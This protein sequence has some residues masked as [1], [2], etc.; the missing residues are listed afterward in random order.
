MKKDD[1]QWVLRVLGEYLLIAATFWVAMSAHSIFVWV[2]CAWF[3][4]NRAHALGVIGHWGMHGIIPRWLMWLSFIPVGI[5]PDT[6]WRGHLN[7]HRLLG[8]HFWDPE[9]QVFDKYAD[10]WKG[11]NAWD[12][13]LD[14]FW[15][16]LGESK[17][18]M[19]LLVSPFSIGLYIIVWS[20]L[21]WFSLGWYALLWPMGIGGLLASHRI[22][23]YFEHDHINRPGYTRKN[24]KPPLWLRFLFLPHYAWKHWEHHEFPSRRVWDMGFYRKK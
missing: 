8:N 14:S 7:H 9:K 23:A 15:F 24:D 19:Q 3:L 4:G 5:D 6:Y 16:R 18:I 17:D 10:R 1:L 13:M 2:L 22:R 20:L 21:G 11:V 12:F